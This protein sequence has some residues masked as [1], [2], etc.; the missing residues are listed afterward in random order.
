MLAVLKAKREEGL[1]FGR[2]GKLISIQFGM[3][4]SRNSCISKANRA[5]L[6]KVMTTDSIRIRQSYVPRISPTERKQRVKD[7]LVK[8]RAAKALKIA[9]M[10]DEEIAVA[11]QGKRPWERKH[12][13][14]PEALGQ[15]CETPLLK[16]DECLWIHGHPS[17]DSDWRACAHPRRAGSKYCGHH[18]KR[19]YQASRAP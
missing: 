5:G 1:S 10:T 18:H 16:S 2:I 12:E 13:G 14:E 7:G 17:L 15:P 8:A 4:I 9:T 3:T 19:H 6:P 11:R